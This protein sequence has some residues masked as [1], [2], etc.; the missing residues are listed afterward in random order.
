MMN[1]SLRIGLLAGAVLVAAP[2][3]ADDLR[4]ALAQAYQTNPTLQ[5]ARASQRATD[6]EVPIQQAGAA[7]NISATANH[8]EF[9]KVSPNSFGPG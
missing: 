1:G 6:E 8:I 5:A 9:L 3:Q 2:A 7:P 4:A